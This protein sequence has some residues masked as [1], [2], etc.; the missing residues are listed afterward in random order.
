MREPC[1]GTRA[2]FQEDKDMADQNEAKTKTIG[3][4]PIEKVQTL[5]GWD[6]YADKSTK[7][8][9]LRTEAQKAKNSVR[10]ALKERLNEN[11]DIDFVVEGDRIRVFR[12]FR[13]QQQGRRTRSLDLSS[14]F[15]EQGLEGQSE[16]NGRSD[17]TE[18]C[19][20][21]DE[22]AEPIPNLDPVTERLMAI[23]REKATSR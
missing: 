23:M 3:F 11:G 1:F 7:L 15:R 2:M 9:V 17:K 13:K 20:T 10:D 16:T 8:S 22:T 6:E 21:S 5:N 14:S 18:E 12:V 19:S 4:L